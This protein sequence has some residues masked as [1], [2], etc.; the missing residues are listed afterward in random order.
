MSG[1]TVAESAAM[2]SSVTVSPAPKPVPELPKIAVEKPASKSKAALLIAAVVT[3][4]LILAVGIGGFWLWNRSRSTTTGSN[5]SN[6]NGSGEAVVNAPIEISRYWLELEPAAS[7]AQSNRVAGLVPLASGQSF[8]FHFAFSEEGYLYIFGPGDNNQPTAFL[9]TKPLAETGVKS[10]KVAKGVE[11]SFPSG[12][13]NNVTLD[14]NPGTDNF[15]VIFSRT[16]LPLPSFLN[17]PVTGRPLSPAQQAELKSFVSK[18]QEK[19]VVTELD[20]S[21]ARAPFVKVK[22]APEQTSDP[23]VFDIRI[24]HN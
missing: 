6:V 7:G 3:F 11:F 1:A 24:Q 13:G 20:E 19:R 18:Y 4:G 17:E 22:A 23:V 10:N 2:A 15:T 5:G 8:K 21:N 14:K 9:T 16:Q 12:S